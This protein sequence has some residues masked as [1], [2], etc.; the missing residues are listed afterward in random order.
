[1][2]IPLYL[3]CGNK[4]AEFHPDALDW[5]TPKDTAAEK[6]PE[7]RIRSGIGIQRTSPFSGCTGLNASKHG[8]WLFAMLNL[9]LP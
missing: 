5:S 3:G 1:M 6:L 7:N 8:L 4:Y 9:P 2:P